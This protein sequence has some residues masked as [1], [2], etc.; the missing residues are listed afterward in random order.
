MK[1]RSDAP[2]QGGR[3]QRIAIAQQSEQVGGSSSG[4]SPHTSHGFDSELVAHLVFEWSWGH[5][6]APGMQAIAHKAFNDQVALLSS[7]GM[8]P[9]NISSTLKKVASLGTWGK[10][11][12][13]CNR[14]LL[15]W[16]GEPDTPPPF[17]HPVPLKVPKATEGEPEIRTSDF[18]I[19]LPHVWF[20][21]YYNTNRPKFESLFLGDHKSS[22]QIAA[23]WTELSSRNDP[24]LKDHPMTKTADWKN[25]YVPLSLHGDGVPVLQVGKS[26]TRSLDVMS[27]S[28]LFCTAGSS[29]ESQM[30]LWMAFLMNITEMSEVE[31]W[32]ILLWSFHWLYRGIWPLVDHN[33]QPWPKGSAEATVAGTPLAGGLKAVLFIIKA[34]LEFLANHLN[35][36]HYNADSMCEFCPAH[37]NIEDPG[38]CFNN[39]GKS[40]KWV[41]ALFSVDEWLAIHDGERPHP[42]FKIL[43]V[44]HYSIEPDELHIIYLGALQYMLGSI[45]YLLVYKFMAGTAEA[46][47]TEVWC[48]ISSDYKANKV[49][50]QLGNCSLSSFVDTKKPHGH[51]P[52]LRG[53]G[54]ETKDLVGALSRAWTRFAPEGYEHKGI[55]SEMLNHQLGLQSILSEH[56]RDMFLP[57]DAAKAF[58]NHVCEVLVI[59]HRLAAASDACGDLLWNFPTK[60]HWLWHLGERSQYLNPRRASCAIN[61]DFV[62]KMKDITHACASGTELHQM[63]IKACAKYRW[64]FHF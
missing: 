52:R 20:S 8:S 38:F 59:Y 45:L 26:N 34:D 44:A 11:D 25:V 41:T 48:A 1:R 51:F 39:F 57:L 47:M 7:L 36:R 35:C 4:D 24:R 31:I 42:V 21:H 22:N 61:E 56:K 43:G 37:R 6:S 3:L 27:M 12:Q 5:V 18:P 33:R 50:C 46:N 64:G 63:S 28:S 13:N 30:T 10:N 55:I 54:Q 32:R 58:R 15:Q 49:T 60:W 19:F 62:G 17:M 2:R 53:K 23:F 16:L 29:L 40:A 14:E 9:D